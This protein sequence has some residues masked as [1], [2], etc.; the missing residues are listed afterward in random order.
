M[1]NS[2]LAIM[3]TLSTLDA[4]WAAG[5][6]DY[7]F[8]LMVQNVSPKIGRRPA[9]DLPASYI[10]HGG[11]TYGFQSDNGYFPSL[12]ASISVV[13]NQDSDFRCY[14]PHRWPGSMHTL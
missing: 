5:Y 4:G 10:G 1:S 12:N 9:L 14:V 2:S 11:D 8:G 7:G 6:L 13:V 3:E